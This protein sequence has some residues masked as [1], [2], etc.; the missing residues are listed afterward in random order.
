MISFSKF[1]FVL[2]FQNVNLDLHDCM[3]KSGV[4]LQAPID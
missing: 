1:L 4:S 3:A 2:T